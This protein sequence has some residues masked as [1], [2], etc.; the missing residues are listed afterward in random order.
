MVSAFWLSTQALEKSAQVI[1]YARHGPRLCRVWV[2]A[3]AGKVTFSNL[4]A[5]TSARPAQ[6]QPSGIDAGDAPRHCRGNGDPATMKLRARGPS[7]VLAGIA[8]VV[9][10]AAAGGPVAGAAPAASA[11]RAPLAARVAPASAPPTPR[12][13]ARAS[14]RS[15]AQAS[16]PSPAKAPPDSR[17][18]AS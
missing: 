17:G 13:Q 7:V 2:P 1:P 4:A 3:E 15:P 10:L 16:A 6:I 11:G 5:A 14:D 8:A 12:S 9:G 18:K